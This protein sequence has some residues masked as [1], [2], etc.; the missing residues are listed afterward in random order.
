MWKKVLFVFAVCLLLQNGSYAMA[1]LQAAPSV[2]KQND[3][4]E[5]KTAALSAGNPLQ[6]VI[7][8]R[9]AR[10]KDKDAAVQMKPVKEE[11]KRNTKRIFINLASHSLAVYDG[12]QK[13]NLYPVGLGK[14][15]TPTPTG[16]YSILE[17]IENPEWVDPENPKVCVPSGE[18]NP[19]GYR[20]MQIYGNYGIHG[21]NKP[22]SV[23]GYFSNGCIRMKEADVEALYTKVEVGTPVEIT[24]NR[25]VVEKLPDHTIAYYVYPD[26]Y[27]RQPLDIA[28]I[29]AWLTGYGVGDFESDAAIAAKIEASDGQPTFVARA[30][31]LQVNGKELQEKA[32]LKDDSWYLPAVPL[33]VSTNLALEWNSDMGLLSSP[34]GDAPGSAERDT[35]YCSAEGAA[36]LY[37]LAGGLNAE[38]VY[39]LNTAV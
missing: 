9:T 7:E 29:Q 4:A 13:I 36:V 23:G 31:A 5:N 20:W 26:S 10:Q 6:P 22:E 25:V 35:L 19:L 12:N 24:Y 17:K 37:H 16:Y 14:P 8:E 32:V 39:I 34:Y 11:K 18:Q 3:A 27:G 1:A 15:A 2:A 21:T 28:A 30:Y 38:G 33:A